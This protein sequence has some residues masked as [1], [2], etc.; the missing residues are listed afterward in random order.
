MRTIRYYLPIV[1]I[2]VTTFYS[3][4][5]N[6]QIEQSVFGNTFTTLRYPIVQRGFNIYI[7]KKLLELNVKLTI[8]ADSTF[9]REGCG[10]IVFGEASLENDTLL[11][12]SKRQIRKMD[13]LVYQFQKPFPVEKYHI[14]TNGILTSELVMPNG[15]L[16]GY[17]LESR[18][19]FVMDSIVVE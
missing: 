9:I 2:Y 4:G 5:R 7:L 1:L 18:L 3:C 11:L 6:S 14:G 8:N 12:T 16:K 17:I 10:A 13:S 15:E 19:V